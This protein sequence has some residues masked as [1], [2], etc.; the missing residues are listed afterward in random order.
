MKK[1]LYFLTICILLS[2]ASPLNAASPAAMKTAEKEKKQEVPPPPPPRTEEETED[3][4]PPPPIEEDDV[5][6]PPPVEIEERVFTFPTDRKEPRLAE[7]Q[8]TTIEFTYASGDKNRPLLKVHAFENGIKAGSASI[9]YDIKTHKAKLLNIY[10]QG[11][12]RNKG[13]GALIWNRMIA[14]LKNLGIKKL[15]FTAALIDPSKGEKSTQ[16]QS[17]VNWYK[18][19]GART[20][21]VD[22]KSNTTYM[23]LDL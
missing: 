8:Y 13:F 9:E 10:V 4:P 21:S 23:E 16:L 20:I 18:K 17:L 3:V 12:Y 22:T 15:I 19:R 2:N 5:P 7:Q 6:P 14:E 1:L 11:S